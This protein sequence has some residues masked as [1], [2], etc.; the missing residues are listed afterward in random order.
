MLQLMSETK[1]VKF[2]GTVVRFEPD[3]FGLVQ[4]DHPIGP[5]GNGFGLISNSTGT[6][7]RIRG[8]F[9]LQIGGL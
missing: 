6:V 3:G 8:I 7:V 5:S 1:T 2:S 4:F 9:V